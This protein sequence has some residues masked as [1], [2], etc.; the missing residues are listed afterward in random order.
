MLRSPFRFRIAAVVIAVGLA[1]CSDRL[2]EPAAG[3]PPVS[4]DSARSVRS[5]GL[6]AITF[7]AA[8]TSAMSASAHWV[9]ESRGLPYGFSPASSGSGPSFTLSPVE[10]GSASGIQLEPAGHGYA[11]SGST[12]YL[13]ASFRARNAATNGVAYTVARRNITFVAY[14][15]PST[16]AQTAVA[17]L[18][19]FD[20][21]SYADASL[22]DDIARSVLPAHGVSGAGTAVKVVNE[23]ADMQA[24]SESEVATLPTTDGSPLAYGYVVRCVSN[25]A[26]ARTL[27]ANP[28]SDQFDGVITFAVKLPI[29]ATAADNPFRFT[30]MFEAVEDGTTRLTQS[31]EEQGTTQAVDRAASLP[32]PTVTVLGNT[33][34]PAGRYGVERLCRVRTAGT[35]PNAP[36]RTLIDAGGCS[37]GAVSLPTNVR[38][39]DVAA[40]AAGNGSSWPTAFNTLQDVLTCVRTDPSCTGVTEIWVRK[41]VYYP[42]EGAGITNGDAA[43]TFTLVPG[44]ALYGGFAGGEMS[45][46]QRDVA[47][48]V[49][50]LSGDIGKDD[51]NGDG[52]FVIEDASVP[53]SVIGSNSSHVLT[54]PS[55]V[56]RTTVLDG[57]TITAGSG[58]LDGA[59]L[60]CATG[61]S[62]QCSLTLSH[63]VF[64]GNSAVGAGAGV[65]ID[66]T[67]AGGTA[68]PLLA[69]VTFSGNFAS[70]VG[71]ALAI[72][73]GSSSTT[74][75]ALVRVRFA[76]NT[77]NSGGGAVFLSGGGGTCTAQFVGATFE[78]NRAINTSHGGAVFVSN[79]SATF[80]DAVFWKNASGAQGG[81]IYHAGTSHSVF[82]NVTLAGNSAS[83]SGGAVY[84]QGSGAIA[85]EFRNVI[86]WANTATSAPGLFLAAGTISN[87]IVQ[88]GCPSVATCSNVGSSD[89][90]FMDVVA[91]DLR[92]QI[93]SPALDAGDLLLLPSDVLDL[94]GDAD[95]LERL[96]LDVALEP[97]IVNALGGGAKVDLGAHER[98]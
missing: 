49:T 10:D 89:P 16:R 83:G 45:R 86:V 95:T 12:R 75:P 30:M 74:V 55:T 53:G 71:G 69:D 73:A 47:T 91:G 21:S 44:V 60:Y 58:T 65:S 6:V 15:T 25:C 37:E 48:N 38:V 31:I 9:R 68:A 2:T 72:G 84:S 14:I 24:L 61:A 80:A 76:R 59:G 13:S 50:I 28:A 36:V 97:R 26:D 19:R 96:P 42:D 92:L 82:A 62:G 52:N 43:A 88:G 90:L 29:Q 94:D 63:L 78:S 17:S 93:N 64:S 11:D 7:E 56:T 51:P 18:E 67:G 70:G 8:G 85:P 22:A 23:L 20:G 33:S 5:L 98:Q 34:T 57:F 41:G 54:A 81:A 66:A 35:D 1:A 32:N 77:S 46:D 3:H 79:C 87:A 4:S 39:V 27:A 40:S